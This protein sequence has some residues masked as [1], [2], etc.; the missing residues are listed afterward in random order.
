MEYAVMA[1]RAKVVC[2]GEMLLRLATPAGHT[3]RDVPA[4]DLVVGGAEAN[5]AVALSAL[6]HRCAMATALP[7]NPLGVRAGS[8]LAARGVDTSPIVWRDGRMGLYF[9]EVGAGLR[10]SAITYD[11][12]GSAFALCP[13]DAF[14]FG[15][16]LAGA[17]VLHLSGITAALGPTGLA[18]V[19]AAIGAA[20][21]AGAAVSFDPNFRETLWRAW[22]PDPAP[23]LRELA[24]SADVLFAGP[25]DM[26]LMLGKPC[27]SV[28]VAAEQAFAAFPRLAVMA[29][30]LRETPGQSHHRLAARVD[31]REGSHQTAPIDVPGIIDRIGTGDAFAAGVLHGW[32]TGADAT[33]M[34]QT[35][36]ALGALKHGIHGDWCSVGQ[37]EID[38]FTGSG[39]DVRR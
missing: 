2:F 38:A 34:A 31:T 4:L 33:A 15:S 32:L 11:R 30:T 20:R 22:C 8:A 24:A 17:Q 14:D 6:G 13:P 7:D 3:M 5:V 1:N 16:I 19:R 36:L 28:Q 37:A 10:A 39:A 18:L 26:A 25:R 21:A 27:G 12:A 9:L 35:G 23:I 29:S